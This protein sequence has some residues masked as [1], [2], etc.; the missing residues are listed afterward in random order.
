[1]TQKGSSDG[2]TLQINNQAYMQ[3]TFSEQIVSNN[4]THV[5]SQ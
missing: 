3:V 5:L 1:M 2:V 4:A